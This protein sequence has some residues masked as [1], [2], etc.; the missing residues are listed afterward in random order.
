[1]GQNPYKLGE[2]V[3]KNTVV[4][5]V[6]TDV[7]GIDESCLEWEEHEG[8]ESLTLGQI[9]EQAK[10]ITNNPEPTIIVTCELGLW[11][12]VFGLK[13]HTG[14]APTWHVCGITGGYA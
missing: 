12:T 6:W 4:Y 3:D 13:K 8:F 9:F 11:G 1:M 14:R 2:V 5:K 10:A 7:V